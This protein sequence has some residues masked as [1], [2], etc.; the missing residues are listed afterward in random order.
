AR[1]WAW[2]VLIYWFLLQ[3]FQGLAELGPVRPDVSG[4]VAV[5]AHVGGFV[6]GLLLVKLF[7]NRTLVAR[8]FLR[9]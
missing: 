2:L 1:I 7:V 8:P 4:G 5:W 3:L 6:T 9:R